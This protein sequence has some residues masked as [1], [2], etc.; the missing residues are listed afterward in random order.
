M[1]AE[2]QQDMQVMAAQVL[3][4]QTLLVARVLEGAEVEVVPVTVLVLLTTEHMYPLVVVA[5]VCSRPLLQMALEEPITVHIHLAEVVVRAEVKAE[6][7][8]KVTGLA[9]TIQAQN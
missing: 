1:V 3:L 2:V 7:V 5:L 8:D 9:R 4:E 6:R